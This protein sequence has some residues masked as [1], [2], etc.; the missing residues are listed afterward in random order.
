MESNV[1][2]QIEAKRAAGL[3]TILDCQNPHEGRT[4]ERCRE[5]GGVNPIPA[6]SHKSV[7]VSGWTRQW[8]A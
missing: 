7:Q 5:H 3:C 2:A 4:L 8:E 6:R 1:F